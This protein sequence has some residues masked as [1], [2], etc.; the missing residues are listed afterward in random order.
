MARASFCLGRKRVRHSRS[1]LRVLGLFMLASTP[2]Y[3]Q[4]VES[5]W[6][7]HDPASTAT[8]DHSDW[9]AVLDAHLI[10][11]DPSGVHLFDY[12]ALQTNSADRGAARRLP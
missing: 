3:G 8:I 4:P 1:V 5:I 9:Q 12:G 2:S 7:Q 11:D 10:T 6:E